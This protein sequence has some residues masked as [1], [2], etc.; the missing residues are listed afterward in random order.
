MFIRTYMKPHILIVNNQKMMAEALI[1]LLKDEANFTV[2]SIGE[3]KHCLQQANF[4]YAIVDIDPVEGE[5]GLSLIAP[6]LLAKMKPIVMASSAS[7]GQIRAA[8]RLGAYGYI[9][10]FQPSSHL[11]HVLNEVQDRRFSFPNGMVDELR[12]DS[13]LLL[14][15]LA[16]SEKRLLDYFVVHA[17]QSNAQIGDKLALSE[18]RIRNCMTELMRKF[19]VRSRSMLLTEATFRGYFPGCLNN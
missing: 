15:K 17:N 8:I 11:H 9:D 13:K 18:G 1:A 14:P 16:K 7:V 12:Q 6:M 4:S 10:K 5:Y 19:G 3:A 2:A